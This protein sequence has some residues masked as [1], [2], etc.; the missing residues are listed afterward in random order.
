VI[1]ACRRTTSWTAS[2]TQTVGRLKREAITRRAAL[3]AATL[4]FLAAHPEQPPVPPARLVNGRIMQAMTSPS[5]VMGLLDPWWLALSWLDHARRLR[6]DGS[7]E[8]DLGGEG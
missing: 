4:G 6:G 1:R 2:W 8:L 3:E 7:D 5:M